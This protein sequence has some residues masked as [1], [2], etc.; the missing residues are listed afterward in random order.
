MSGGSRMSTVFEVDYEIKTGRRVARAPGLVRRARGV[1]R[2]LLAL[3]DV[4]MLLAAGSLAY[5]A[6]DL[7]GAGLEAQLYLGLLPMLGAFVAKYAWQ[8]LYPAVGM[9]VV[10]EF[11]RLTI[12]TTTMFLV[13][14]ALTYVMRGAEQYSRLVLGM[15][16]LFTLVLVPLG[17]MLMR[18]AAVGL[19]VWGEPVMIVGPAGEA[20]ATARRF[21]RDPKLGIRP[22]AVITD[23]DVDGLAVPAGVLV[24]PEAMLGAAREAF[25]VQTVFALVCGLDELAAVRA[26]YEDEFKRINVI[27]LGDDCLPILGVEAVAFGGMQGL[28]VRQSLLDGPAQLQKRVVDLVISIAGL[29]LLTPLLAVVALLI[30]L[31]SPGPVF[32]TQ[33]RY[34][35]R[36]RTLNMLKF[37]TMYVNADAV[38]EQRLAED[39]G[40]RREWLEFQ[41]L[42]DDPRITRVGRLLR[43]FSIDELPQLWNVYVGEMSVVGPRPIM[44]NQRE[45]YGRA[46]HE[47]VR[48]TP[49]ITGMW[50]ISG[51]N[52]V[53]FARRTELDMQYVMGWSLWLDIY[54]L[55]RTVWVVLR[56]EGA[57]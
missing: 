36:G 22:V 21:L 7:L 33:K 25:N 23:E 38:L 37:R 17:R 18:H 26:R 19:G 16:Y 29:A 10:E 6:R 52:N 41:K 55:M 43:R 31:D 12:S 57:G 9:G 27:K 39:E 49:G 47:Y 5:H 24:K 35:R 56:C 1:M 30:K 42:K 40:L 3:S 8:G 53:S 51:R 45:L 50:Q 13:M 11:K 14:I 44:M 20:L 2:G 48:V 34:G 28:Q 15:A 32:Y 4:V 46:I 54:I